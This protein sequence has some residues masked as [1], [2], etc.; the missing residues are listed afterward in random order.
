MNDVENTYRVPQRA[1]RKWDWLAR[2]VFNQTYASMLASQNLFLHP[3]Q[4][5]APNDR[6]GTTCWNAAWTAAD[7]VMGRDAVKE[8]A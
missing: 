6:W 8:R 7:A 5:P 1:W 2:H 4:R 3:A